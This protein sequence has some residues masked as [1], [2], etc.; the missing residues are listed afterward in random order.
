VKIGRAVA[1]TRDASKHGL[2]DGAVHV[3]DDAPGPKREG[4]ARCADMTGTPAHSS[5][6]TA[7]ERTRVSGSVRLDWR[8]RWT[9]LARK[10]GNAYS[11]A[12]IVT[13]KS[14]AG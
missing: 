6:I 11:C 2:L 7:T 12:L 9:P 3:G 10:R 8:N 5:F 14:R 13:P 4:D 1:A